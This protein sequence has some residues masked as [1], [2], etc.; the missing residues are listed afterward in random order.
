MSNA[1]ELNSQTKWRDVQLR[2]LPR[3]F[4][5]NHPLYKFPGYFPD[6]YGRA[7]TGKN[8]AWFGMHLLI[9]SVIFGATGQLIRTF[10]NNRLYHTGYRPTYYHFHEDRVP[11]RHRPIDI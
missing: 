4:R 1:T 9:L 7:F 8:I 6:W 5:L 2:D 11:N 10:R 3:Y